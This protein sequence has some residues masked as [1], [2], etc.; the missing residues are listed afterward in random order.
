MITNRFQ[1]FVGKPLKDYKYNFTITS[2]YI[3]SIRHSLGH[4]YMFLLVYIF[5]YIRNYTSI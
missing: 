4:I 2:F 5:I 1:M 3:S